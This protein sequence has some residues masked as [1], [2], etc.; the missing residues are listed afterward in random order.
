M[1][2]RPFPLPPVPQCDE[3]EVCPVIAIRPW[4]FPLE[5]S[6]SRSRNIPD[7]LCSPLCPRV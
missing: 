1:A 5:W 6:D 2:R 7:P 4:S 3:P